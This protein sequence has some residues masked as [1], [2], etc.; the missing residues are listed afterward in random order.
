MLHY[1]NWDIFQVWD[2]KIIN[3]NSFGI[4]VHYEWTKS[5][6][7]FFIYPMFDTNLW[8]FS[9]Y[10][11][12]TFEQKEFFITVLKISWIWAKTAYFLS[13]LDKE[14]IQKAIEDF[15]LK[16]FQKLPWIWPKT[17]KRILLELKS[18]IKKS[19]IAKL[20]IDQDLLN[21]II[22]TLKPY[23]FETAKL[24]KKL[25]WC[26]LDLDRSNMENI[27]KWIFENYEN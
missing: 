6:W 12:D 22:K 4:Q 2:E 24:K 10:A 8:T 26:P 1:I 14:E 5:K 20:N 9:Y 27:I 3:N 25:E 17:A 21:D 13:T 18:K 15:D 11:F 23:W 16:Y 19:D 7:D